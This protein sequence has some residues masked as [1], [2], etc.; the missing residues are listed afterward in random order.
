MRLQTSEERQ[1]YKT[2]DV[3]HQTLSENTECYDVNLER[4]YPNKVLYVQ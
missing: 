2:P 4:L 3:R 1:T